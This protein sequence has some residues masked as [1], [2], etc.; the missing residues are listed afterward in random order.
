MG[1]PRHGML[2][3]IMTG[4]STKLPLGR[5]APGRCW[6]GNVMGTAVGIAAGGERGD[7]GWEGEVGEGGMLVLAAEYINSQVTITSSSAW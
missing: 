5:C 1:D 2:G 4:L 6:F 3:E 7:G